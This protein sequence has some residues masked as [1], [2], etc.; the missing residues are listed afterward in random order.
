MPYQRYRFIHEMSKNILDA[1]VKEW[2]TIQ[3]F[4]LNTDKTGICFRSGYD[5]IQTELS[6][7]LLTIKVKGH[8]VFRISGYFAGRVTSCK[9]WM[10]QKQRGSNLFWRNLGLSVPNVNGSWLPWREMKTY[11]VYLGH[12]PIISYLADWTSGN[13]LPN[14]SLRLC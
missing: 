11:D 5:F 13:Y 12:E 3:L 14:Y 9:Y 4:C 2:V 10:C 1:N 8:C 6:I 7:F